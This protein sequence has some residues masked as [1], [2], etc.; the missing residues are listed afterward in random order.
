MDEAVKLVEDESGGG[1]TFM[2]LVVLEGNEEAMGLYEMVKFLGGVG[3]WL[4]LG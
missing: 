1:K 4:G 3:E 2:R